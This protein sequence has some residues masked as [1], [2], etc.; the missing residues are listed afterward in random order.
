MKLPAHP[1]RVVVLG[2][3]T[4]N[5][6][7]LGVNL[8]GVDSWSKKNPR[9]QKELK[10]VEEVSDANIEKI[11]KLKPDVIIGLSNTKNVEKLKKKSHQ[12]FYLRITKLITFSSTLK[13]EKY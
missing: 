13:L 8:V 5:V 4:G 3:Y 6:M 12:P 11:M 7:S 2:S 1:K 10:G 9:F